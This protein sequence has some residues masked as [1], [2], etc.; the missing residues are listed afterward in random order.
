M[1]YQLRILKGLFYPNRSLFQL[2]KAE[3]VYGLRPNILLLFFLSALVFSV[4]GLAGI[5]SHVISSEL[6]AVSGGV[7]EWL[8]SYFVLG[9]FIQGLL[10][11]ALVIF[12]QALW[13]WTLTDAPYPKLVVL[14]AFILPILLLEQIV[15]IGLA[16]QMNLPWFSSPFSFGPAAHYITDKRFLIYFLGC[17]SLFKIWVISIQLYGLRILSSR[18]RLTSFFIIL[19]IHV[20]FWLGTAFLAF[21]N[22]K[23]IL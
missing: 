9:R 20:I 18:R 14:Q 6:T 23:K 10:Y 3:A 1:I 8:K 15:N 5:G 22:F 16:V 12:F 11:A 13:F 7:F 21:L 19:G 4:S 2:E 17:I